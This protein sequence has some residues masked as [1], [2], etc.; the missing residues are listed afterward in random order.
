MFRK[1]LLSFTIDFF[2][3]I[4]PILIICFL[5]VVF[6][7]G[8]NE[9]FEKV[10]Y[11]IMLLSVLCYVFGIY[12]KD[13]IGRRSIG[14]R[15]MHL[16]IEDKKGYKPSV[17]QLIVRNLSFLI[18]PVEVGLLLRDKERIGDKIA[19][20]RVVEE[21]EARGSQ[22]DGSVDTLEKV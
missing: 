22:G 14:N 18:W 17:I 13:I 8:I 21:R 6:E 19:Q 2:I 16:K 11:F 4:L 9:V 7:Q 12:L 15:I 10:L 3:I 1:R 5:Y 20:T